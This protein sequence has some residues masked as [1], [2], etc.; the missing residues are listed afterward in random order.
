RLTH[1]VQPSSTWEETKRTCSDVFRDRG[2]S[3]VSNNIIKN[4]NMREEMVKVQNRDKV[5]LTL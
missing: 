1:L 4:I 5:P 3:T 2:N